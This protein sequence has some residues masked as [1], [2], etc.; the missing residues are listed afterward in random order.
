MDYQLYVEV[1]SEKKD[2]INFYK[3]YPVEKIVIVKVLG[4]KTW[5]TNSTGFILAGKKYYAVGY[6]TKSNVLYDTAILNP[7]NITPYSKSKHFITK[8][9]FHHALFYRIE[10]LNSLNINISDIRLFEISRRCL[11]I[12]FMDLD[13]EILYNR[14]IKLLEKMKVY[15]QKL[16]KT[17]QSDNFLKK[18]YDLYHD[19]TPIAM[20][21]KYGEK[22]QAL[23][24]KWKLDI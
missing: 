19:Y 22:V 16:Y 7:R 6:T 9:E 2:W 13:M 10:L 8:R 4:E 3:N 17:L 1:G 12:V 14:E 24:Y 20:D 18:V 21:M 11:F 15:N 5:I 23:T